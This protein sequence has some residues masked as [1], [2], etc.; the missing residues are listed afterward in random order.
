MFLLAIGA[1]AAPAAA[2]PKTAETKPAAA[3]QP[4]AA[5]V[6]IAVAPDKLERAKSHNFRPAHIAAAADHEEEKQLNGISA[7]PARKVVIKPQ[8]P[9]KPK[10]NVT[11][12]GEDM[13]AA[14]K[15][16]VR[17]YAFQVR[18]GG[19]PIYTLIWEW[20]RSPNQGGKGWTLDTRMHVASV[21]KLLTAVGVTR[22]LDERNLPFDT[23]IGSYLPSH[24]SVGS[25]SANITFK[26]L[27]THRAGFN[28]AHHGGDYATFK[29]QIADGV[30][31][32]SSPV[33]TNGAFSIMRVLNA[34]MTG[35]VPKNATFNVPPAQRDAIWD[36]VTQ[37]AFQNYMNAK[38]FAPS[39]V[40]G[41]TST[42]NA[43]SALAYSTKGDGNGWDSGDLDTQIGG[44]GFRV[45]VNDVLNVMGTFRRKGTIVSAAK[46]QASLDASLGI[47][48][49]DDTPA[50][51]MYLKNGWWGGG[52]KDG[53][54]WH[55]EQAVAAYLPDDME[56]VVLVNS[57]IGPN[58]A[59]LT[60][61]F[62]NAVLNNIE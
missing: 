16:N 25:N 53:A 24:W 60:T 42:G 19:N 26:E 15:D 62:R 11:K 20:S 10:L 5:A 37:D 17:G 29:D 51:K 49:I 1:A 31:A 21:S 59:S 43:N 27:L 22:M 61:T 9:A 47:D 41:I 8:Q 48:R 14:L 3:A 46:A 55:V 54:N 58:G 32:N 35:V 4:L 38:V 28:E 18:K 50:G 45:S 6:T 39:S 36:I 56:A 34:T 30:P 44:A 40:T 2:Q 12:M 52:G 13:H 33:Y 57:N 23:K 7:I